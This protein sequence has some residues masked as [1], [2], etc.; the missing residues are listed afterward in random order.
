[1]PAAIDEN[2]MS[3]ELGLS[4]SPDALGRARDTPEGR[5]SMPAE[6]DVRERLHGILGSSDD[7]R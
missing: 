6:E 5:P 7:A 3:G 4:S 1:M 2:E